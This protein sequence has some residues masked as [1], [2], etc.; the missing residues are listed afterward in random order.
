[1]KFEYTGRHMGVSPAL[2]THV[3]EHFDRI[4]HLFDGNNAHAHVIIE[5]EK[6]R[7]RSEII[8]KWR[9]DVLTANTTLSDMYQSLSQTIAKIEKQALKLK[10]KTI[11]KYHK[12]EKVSRVSEPQIDAAPEDNSPRIIDTNNYAVKPMTDEEAVLRLND[13]EN[14]FLVFRNADDEKVSVIYK[15]KDGNYGLIKP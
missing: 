14:Q 7:H 10:K 5:V 12:A 4:N 13:Q 15:R 2:R 6:G 1:M 11:D 3:E 9:K 8:L